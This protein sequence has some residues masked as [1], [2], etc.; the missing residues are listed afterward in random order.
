[1]AHGRTEAGGGSKATG[2]SADRFPAIL[3]DG[4]GQGQRLE[5]HNEMGDPFGG[6]GEEECSLV[7]PST[8]AL[9]GGGDLAVEGRRSSW[10]RRRRGRGG[11]LYSH[12][13]RCGGRGVRRWPKAVLDGE[14]ASAGEE[15]GGR[16]GVSTIP[17]GGRWL[18]V[19]VGLAW[20]QGARG[21]CSVVS[22]RRLEQRSATRGRAEWGGSLVA[23][24]EEEGNGVSTW[25]LRGIR[26]RHTRGGGGY[27]G[28]A[29]SGGG[30]RS[31]VPAR[32]GGW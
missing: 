21:R 28:C 3:D 16:L 8:A 10:W 13:G 29:W 17:Y 20:L 14:A 23:A 15:E 19:V 25:P 2:G 26:A 30:G 31:T 22:V 5:R 4:V 18:R 27:M 9:S 7:S 24:E 32:G 12:G 11:A 6:S 1:V